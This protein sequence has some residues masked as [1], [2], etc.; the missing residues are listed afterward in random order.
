[1]KIL[2]ALT[3]LLSVLTI[4]V[5]AKSEQVDDFYS[6][7]Y[8]SPVNSF[9]EVKTEGIITKKD[10][11]YIYIDSDNLSTSVKGYTL[12][13]NSTDKP[14]TYSSDNPSITVDSNGTVTSDGT[15]VSANITIS[16]G[17]ISITHPVY[18]TNEPKRISLSQNELNLYADRPETVILSLSCEPQEVNL[19]N[20]KWYSGDEGIVHVDST[21]RVIPN[22]VGT[23]SVYAEV[24]GGKLTAKCTVY[25]G[26]YDV[27]IRSVFITNAVDKIKIGSEYS[28]SAYVYP[29]T[30]RDKNIR[31]TSSDN[32]IISVDGNGVIR[33][34]AAGTALI[35]A[36]AANGVK[37][38]FEIESVPAD[39]SNFK[40]K[41]ISKSV[42][43]R[44]AE[45]MTKPHFVKYSYTLDEMTEYQLMTSPVVFSENRPAQREEIKKSLDPSTH[46]SGYGKYQFADLSQTNNVDAQTLN[47]YLSGKGVLEGKGQVFKDAAEKYK[48]SEL[49]LVTHACLESGDGFSTLAS[50][51]EVNGTIVYNMFGI[52]AF[53]SNAV[54]YGS[55]YAYKYGWT[56]VDA[57]ID[58]GAKWISE[59]YI[60]NSSHRQNTL[61]KM[62]WN[63]DSPG[64]HQYAS[65]IA[66]A[67]TQAKIMKSMFDSFPNAELHYEIPLYS[68]E[69]EFELR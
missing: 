68:G 32:N 28:L 1:M 13:L 42:S 18:S 48:L 31:W 3:L 5:Q 38:S 60:N 21:G 33:A 53:D 24:H 44:V 37:D 66:W 46:G 35:T 54:K 67:Q 62:R 12:P 55:E 64:N 59:N 52:G 45:L 23:T 9:S 34:T 4:T 6:H 16:C 8:L 14:I 43:E 47:R 63:P 57:A 65:D 49:Y 30:V 7:L 26:L 61:Y 20:V 50:G 2:P 56:T 39:E 17:D 11:T 25:V 27:S 36:E 19:G 41:I 69:S 40:S 29:E 51:V 22:G 58:G 10:A 15:A